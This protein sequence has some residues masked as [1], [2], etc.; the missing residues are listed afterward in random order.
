MDLRSE[1]EPS[2]L[3]L[4]ARTVAGG[5]FAAAPSGKRARQHSARLGYQPRHAPLTLSQ[6]N[7]PPRQHLLHLNDQED[8]QADP[9]GYE[10]VAEAVRGGAE[11]QVHERGV[12]E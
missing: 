12:N 11:E 5:S 2:R 9:E 4:G 10:P 1:H 8:S 7:P 3:A 6:P